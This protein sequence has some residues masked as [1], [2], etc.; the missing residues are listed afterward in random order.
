MSTSTV[1]RM[2]CSLSDECRAF[3]RIKTNLPILEY[4]DVSL[5]GIHFLF[6]TNHV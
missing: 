3:E 2:V 4:T 1:Q 5:Y 6:I